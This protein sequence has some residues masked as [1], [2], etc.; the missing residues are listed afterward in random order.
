VTPGT[1][2]LQVI[3]VRGNALRRL[4]Q[5]TNLTVSDSSNTIVM[6]GVGGR[7]PEIQGIDWAAGG[8]Q[9]EPETGLSD[10]RPVL[11]FLIAESVLLTTDAPRAEVE[12]WLRGCAMSAA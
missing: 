10:I 3:V 8:S 7:F 11:E 6:R 9:R 2:Y 5:V 12:A 4:R 1:K